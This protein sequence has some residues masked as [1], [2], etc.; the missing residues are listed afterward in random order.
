MRAAT[1]TP[2]KSSRFISVKAGE[3]EILLRL[4]RKRLFGFRCETCGY[5]CTLPLG[6]VLSA[7]LFLPG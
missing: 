3:L 6:L 7:C 4:F 1:S 2:T 5:L